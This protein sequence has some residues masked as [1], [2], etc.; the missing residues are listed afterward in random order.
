MDSP[1]ILSAR[2]TPIGK[3]RGS[4]SGLGAPELGAAAIAAAVAQSGVDPT[5]VDEVI[6][7]IALAAGVGQAPARRA[8]LA[9]GLPVTVAALTINKVCGSGLKAVM[10]AAQAVRAGDAEAVVAGGME[11]MSRAPFVLPR[12]GPAL[13]DRTLIDSLLHDGLSCARSGKAM[14]RIADALACGDAI[15]RHEQ[16][17]Y[18]LESHRR[19]VRAREEGAFQAEIVPVSVP[20]RGEAVEVTNDEGPRPDADPARM[21]ALPAAFGLG[22]TVTAGNAS[23]ISDGAAAVVVASPRLAGRLGRRPL[24]RVIAGATAGV[25]PEDLFV[26]PVAAIRRALDRAGLTI[27]QIDRFELNEAFAAQM[28]A[29]NRRLGLP[30]DRVNEHGGAIAL[31]H[32]IGASGARALVTL[33]HTLDRCGGRFGLVSLCLGGGNAVAMVVER[34]I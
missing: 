20:R 25:E 13:G 11:S 5:D 10:L 4:L 1:V 27:G 6:M 26:A 14:G 8:A 33:L 31:G 12:D 19:A 17:A 15:T 22:G 30:A 23:M 21:A 9:A 32:P 18:A 2:R 34:P 24:A 29:C 3:F 7:G 28:I 16:D